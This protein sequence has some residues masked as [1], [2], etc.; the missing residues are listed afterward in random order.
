MQEPAYPDWRFLAGMTL[1]AEIAILTL[2]TLA[3][4]WAAPYFEGVS[5]S[6]LLS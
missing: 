6:A 4:V 5:L 3:A 1:K 2:L